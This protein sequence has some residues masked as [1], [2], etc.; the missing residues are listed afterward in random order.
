MREDN[1]KGKVGG[2]NIVNFED[3]VEDAEKGRKNEAKL[4]WELNV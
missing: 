3:G 2:S 1:A 4:K